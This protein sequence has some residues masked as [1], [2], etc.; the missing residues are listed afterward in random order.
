[1][2]SKSIFT[3]A[4]IVLMTFSGFAMASLLTDMGLANEIVTQIEMFAVPQWGVVIFA[5][6]LFTFFGMFMESSSIY[7][8]FGPVF[9]PIAIS[10]GINPMMA[11]MMVNVLCNGMGQI[12]PPFALCLLISM[13]IAESDFGKTAQQAV[14]WCFTQYIVV[15]LMLFNLLPMFGMML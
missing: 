13:G 6:L 10:V 15:V 11:A 7:F 12:S 8:L 1:M 5:P 2:L 9:I 14:F 4:P 3:V